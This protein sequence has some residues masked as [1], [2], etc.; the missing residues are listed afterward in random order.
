MVLALLMVRVV[1]LLV[2]LQQRVFVENL[3]QQRVEGMVLLLLLLLW[4]LPLLVVPLEEEKEKKERSSKKNR[5]LKVV[6][7]EISWQYLGS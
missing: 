5:S 7:G 6:F 4:V 1:A 3:W 2:E